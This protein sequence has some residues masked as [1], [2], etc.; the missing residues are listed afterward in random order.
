MIDDPGLAWHLEPVSLILG[1][2]V[3]IILVLTANRVRLYF[4]RVG[5]S[6]RKRY[7]QFRARFGEGDRDQYREA[8]VRYLQG[9]HLHGMSSDLENLYVESRIFS[10]LLNSSA[11]QNANPYQVQLYYLWPELAQKVALTPLPTVTLKQF[12]RKSKRAIISSAPGTGKT[13][14]LAYCA[15]LSCNSKE[16]EKFDF[17]LDALPIYVHLADLP[18]DSYKSAKDRSVQFE[19]FTPLDS[20]IRSMLG[21][22]APKSI[23]Q[24]IE[25]Q[26]HGKSVLLLVDGWDELDLSEGAVAAIWLDLIQKEMPS[27]QI[28]VAVG[29]DGYGP[30][31]ELDFL[32]CGLMP[33]RVGQAGRLGLKLA[34]SRGRLASPPAH[35]YWRPGQTPVETYL[36]ALLFLDSDEGNGEGGSKRLA[37]LM[38]D[39]LARLI[40]K[41]TS[42][43]KPWLGP[44]VKS[45]WQ[46]IAFN[47]LSRKAMSL[48]MVFVEDLSRNILANQQLV[49]NDGEEKALVES[50]WASGLFVKR[51]GDRLGFLSPVWRDFL[52]GSYLADHFL[53]GTS[54][55]KLGLAEWKEAL[56]YYVSLVGATALSNR[57]F[58]QPFSQAGESLFQ[59]ASWMPEVGDT[60][61][62]RRQT[63]V[64]LGRLVVS[65][66]TYALARHRAILALAIT[67]EEGVLVLLRQ[68]I[69]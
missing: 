68:L 48:P 31:L 43:Q 27:A 54:L 30:L 40:D 42:S 24:L 11:E 66:E 61:E 17:L 65:S 58:E 34:Q 2:I 69:S 21:K 13:S 15:L 52:A 9:L 41:T 59:M 44:A 3:G 14:L 45:F 19:P 36:R 10:P 22:A 47:L 49:A 32:L 35:T 63:L 39:T 38:E 57:I 25:N 16:G 64:G 37:F 28:I 60:G 1:L 51:Q 18:L 26:T 8:L 62:W 20:A 55:E 56:R 7:R 29:L 5:D 33:W 53:E 67:G 6:T 46:E 50:L 12:L 4:L 23:R